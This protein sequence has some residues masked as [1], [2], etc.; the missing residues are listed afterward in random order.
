MTQHRVVLVLA[1][2]LLA[3]CSSGWPGRYQ[4]ADGDWDAQ[5]FAPRGVLIEVKT[6]EGDEVGG[7]QHYQL[8]FT[9][10]EHSAVGRVVETDEGMILQGSLDVPREAP[11]S[12]PREQTLVSGDLPKTYEELTPFYGKVGVTL[13]HPDE[14]K[15]LGSSRGTYVLQ[16]TGTHDDG[17]TTLAPRLW[18]V[19]E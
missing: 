14:P 10:G 1:L 13:I 6:L 15:G 2:S 12:L 4:L 18:V 7:D 5:E 9:A 11:L 8:T 17:Q 16:L 19:K 3:G